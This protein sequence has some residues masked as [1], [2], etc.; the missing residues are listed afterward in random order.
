MP[1]PKRE[2][3]NMRVYTT[4]TVNKGSK[5]YLCTACYEKDCRQDNGEYLPTDRVDWSQH[6][7]LTCAICRGVFY[8]F[9]YDGDSNI[10][11]I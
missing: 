7:E 9:A 10:L 2:G 6:T 3:Q 8:R 5:V 4:K 1:E 11:N